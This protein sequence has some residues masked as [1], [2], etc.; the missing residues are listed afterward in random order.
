VN[1][2]KRKVGGMKRSSFASLALLALVGSA[3]ELRAAEAETFTGTAAASGTYK[4]PLLIVDGKRYEL[5]ASDTAD[6]SVAETLAK[7][8]KGDAGTYTVKGKRGTVHGNDSIIIDTITPAKAIP[9][10]GAPAVTKQPGY[11]VYDH[12]EG[13][14]KFRLVVPEKLEVVRGILVVGPYAGGDSRGYHEQVWYREFLNLHGFAFLG[15]TNYYL[16]DYKVMRAALKQFAAD[17][18]HSEL[19]HA[20][21]AATGFSAGGGYTRLL[22]KADPDKVIAG[23]VVGST[24][25]LRGE[26]TDDHRRVPMCVINGDL[27]YEPGEAGGMA[28]ALEP[29]LAEHR[30]KG[31]LWGWMA[32]QGVGHEFAGQEVLAVPMLDAAVRLRYPADA[33]VRKGPVKLKPVESESGWVADNTTWKSGLT[34]VNPAKQ[35][36]G[37]VAK[38]S[39][40]L[41]D[42]IAFIYRAYATHNNPLTITSPKPC[43]PGTPALDAESNVIITIDAGKF[44][45]WKRLEFFDGAKKLGEILPGAATRFTAKNLTPGYHVFSVLATDDKETLRTSNP[46]MVV[47]RKPAARSRQ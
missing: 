25:K 20:P 16:H 33:D 43:G 2:Q 39:W 18:G 46:V 37:D 9:G 1:N 6:A 26:P 30:P 8:S 12:A 44:P 47:V 19:V 14:H 5:K 31:A 13:D 34:V 7:F 35:F 32:V 22:M 23:V 10:T 40:L 41:N 24:M 45:N 15:A 36:K 3:L 4:R 17:F 29:V 21:Y 27:E 11:K 38:S 42:D 28:K